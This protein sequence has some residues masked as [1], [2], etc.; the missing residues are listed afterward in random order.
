MENKF[1]STKLFKRLRY[2]LNVLKKCRI[3]YYFV[4][5]FLS[6]LFSIS[7][8]TLSEYLLYFAFKFWTIHQFYFI[9]LRLQQ[10]LYRSVHQTIMTMNA[11]IHSEF[12]SQSRC[13]A[14]FTVLMSRGSYSQDSQDI[15]VIFTACGSSQIFIW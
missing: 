11:F 1:V 10:H 2:W 3:D 8:G 12:S 14:K 9:A 5:F 6:F 15:F 4:S 7:L 13:Y